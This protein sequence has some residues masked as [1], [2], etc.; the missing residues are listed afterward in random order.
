MNISS[1]FISRPV[2]TT[3]LTIAVA[4][5]GA[6]AFLLLPVS[7]LPPVDFPTI[8]VSASLP[9]ADPETMAT[10]VAAPL[11]RQFGRIA[12][13]TEMT[14]TSYRGTTSIVLQFD[15]N[16]NINGAARDVQAAI[17]AARGFL[18]SNLPNNPTYRKINPADAPIL[19]VAL[20]SDNLTRAEMYDAASSIMQQRLSQVEG[21]GQVFVGGAS[22]PAVRVE[23][24]PTALNSYGISLE[25]VRGVLSRTNTN[26]PKGQIGDSYRSWEIDAN[27]QLHHAYQ[28][29]PVIV[30]YQSGAA[31]RLQDVASVEDSVEDL[32]TAGLVNGKPAVMVIIF[33]QP[34]A[35][36][37]GTVDRV[38]DLLSQL[39]AAMPGGIKFSIIQD[40]TPP[41]RGSLK[42]VEINLM[43]SFA[44]VILVVFLFLR[45]I[46]ST[47]IPGVAVAV[48]LI[49]TFGVM[50]LC[51]YNLD[52]LSL[53]ALTIA[54][55][56][57]VDDA[58]V[59][60]ENITRH[61]EKGTPA[62]EAA[63]LGSREIGF[64]VL[65]MSSSLVAVFIPILLMGGMVG[66]LF[67][68]F[69]VTLSTAIG[70]SLALSLTTTPMM[71]ATLLR[72]GVGRAHGRI[73]RGSERVFDW[74]R[75]RYEVSLRWALQ[76]P[77][78]M[79]LLFVTT[80]ATNVFLF[81]AIPKG[82]F[83]EQDIG[84]IAG[85]IQ[86][87]QNIS[88]Q[89]MEG[90]LEQVL[91]II[92][93]D[94]EVVYIG[95]F[96]GGQGGGGT[97]ANI[98]RMFISLKPF[99][100]RKAT[101]KEVITRLR[102]KLGQI[103]GAPTYLQPVQDLR[104]GGRMSNALYQY[105]LRG[106]NLADLVDWAPRVLQ[107][108]RRL[109]SL[110]DVSSDQQDRGLEATLAIDRNTASRLGITSQMIDDILYDAFGQR[111][112]A[113]TYTQLNQYHVVMEVAPM[114]W[115]RPETLRDIYV[116]SASGA[117]VPL[118]VFAHYDRTATSLAVAHD[119]QFP[120][121]TISFN[122]ASG[123]SL[124]EAVKEV[125]TATRQMGM[126]GS[127]RGSFAGTAQ[128]FEASLAN[129]PLLI[130]AAL[131]AVYI[132]LGILYESYVHPITILST[133]PSAGVGALL[134]LLIFRTDLTIIALIGIILLIG[135]VKKNGIM[136]VDFAIETER[137][138]GRTPVEA[139]YQ[140]CL[141]RFRPIMMTTMA[142][143]LGALPLAL[144]RGVGS[145]LRRPLGIAI[146]GGL[147]FSQSLTL[148]TTPVIY[149]YLD[150]F[151]LRMKGLWRKSHPKMGQETTRDQGGF[152][153]AT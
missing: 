51:G 146:V 117:M 118:S 3:L 42:D 20:T 44:L 56:F 147:I 135:I 84:R 133:L 143:L 61:M 8:N 4:L 63:F 36:I 136:M 121:V 48:S 116:R 92:K 150:R 153:V 106:E 57:V 35:N 83:P 105:T 79:L 119:G 10:S 23:L 90:K 69:A 137:K 67:R 66:R 37:I 24:N 131:V 72:S 28:Y 55:G 64:T 15:L 43:I 82:F 112:V 33:R 73:Y 53:M 93:S 94:P 87:D 65:S 6:V 41:I 11:E 12:G 16:R 102:K 123:K 134:A 115:Q 32:R 97:A 142:A 103:P 151:R 31:V 138:E 39:E 77:S 91:D 101:A 18:P 58:I 7:P 52:N 68:E 34:N 81:M 26:H 98:G 9:G 122:L 149:L 129:E 95:G 54:T 110:V 141:L 29:T 74:M 140:A 113:I 78:L 70:V 85:S 71:C 148:Y 38:R 130:L 25:D 62:R 107:Q 126:P 132:V 47:I 152:E 139:I 49:G 13:V 21:V 1:A 40:R 96:T 22:L 125:E 86:A 89:S 124:G 111:Q 145:E 114:Y 76:H 88:F 46:R 104:I 75:H 50:Y 19:I 127:I 100:E 109:P 128:A 60:L 27:D 120:A 2:A 59:V 108:L 5:A 14:S 80:V 45:T 17:N 144:G 30:S 99:N